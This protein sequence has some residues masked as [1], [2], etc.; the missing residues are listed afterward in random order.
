MRTDVLDGYGLLLC[1]YENTCELLAS[2]HR[3][4]CG[5]RLSM[6]NSCRTLRTWAQHYMYVIVLIIW[7]IFLQHLIELVSISGRCR[8]ALVSHQEDCASTRTSGTHLAMIACGCTCKSESRRTLCGGAM[9]VGRRHVQFMPLCEAAIAEA[10][11]CAA[12]ELRR[13]GRIKRFQRFD[14]DECSEHLMRAT[15]RVRCTRSQLRYAA[16]ARALAFSHSASNTLDS[17]S[18]RRRRRIAHDSLISAA[19]TCALPHHHTELLFRAVQ[20]KRSLARAD[21][22]LTRSLRRRGLCAQD[23]SNFLFPRCADWNF[24]R[25]IW[26]NGYE[27]YSVDSSEHDRRWSSSE[28]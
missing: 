22:M 20:Q 11:R 1:E 12:A 4:V 8:T 16:I 13:S 21:A 15:K 6:F 9:H 7:I 24:H 10:F 3:T 2:S 19:T 23:V 18:D 26:R 17:A 27:S 28:D 14:G 25:V 5:R